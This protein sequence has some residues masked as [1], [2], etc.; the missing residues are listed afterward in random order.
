MSLASERELSEGWG[1][2][3]LDTALV[4]IQ[5]DPPPKS[6]GSSNNHS[7]AAQLDPGKMAESNTSQGARVRQEGQGLAGTVAK[8]A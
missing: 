3:L 2:G 7:G 4:D 6:F 5:S 1:Q 8:G